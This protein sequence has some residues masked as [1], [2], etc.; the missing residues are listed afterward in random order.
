MT[1][2]KARPILETR[3]RRELEAASLEAERRYRTL[4]E[5]ADFIERQRPSPRS[6]LWEELSELAV[7]RRSALR[8]YNRS[9]GKLQGR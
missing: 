3:L 1:P 8:E 9:L 5:R 6:P 7:E 2:A 4:V